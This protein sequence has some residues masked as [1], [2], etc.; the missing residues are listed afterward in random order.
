VNGVFRFENV[1]FAY[2]KD[3]SKIVLQNLNLEINCRHTGVMGESGCGKSTILQ[4]MMRFYDPDE[5]R[6]TLDGIDLRQFDLQWLRQQIGYIGQEP[7]LF[8]TTIREN[9]LI[10]KTDATEEEL[11]EALRRA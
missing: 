4:M 1:S 10:G 3:K 5:G 6:V 2:P 11:I 9:L 8:S 7:L